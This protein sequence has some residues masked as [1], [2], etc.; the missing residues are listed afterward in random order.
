[1][2][3]AYDHPL[4]QLIESYLRNGVYHNLGGYER[5]LEQL[6]N[7][8]WA[9]GECA[10][11]SWQFVAFASSHRMRLKVRDTDPDAL[12]YHDRT[13]RG[14]NRHTVA[15]WAEQLSKNGN[16]MPGSTLYAVDWTCA[17]YGYD[18]FPMVL[19]YTGSGWERVTT[20]ALAAAA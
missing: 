13:I 2:E 17:Q 18:A 8:Q 19:L 11:L 5:S 15:V 12:G 7:P 14:V 6:R 10:N 9:G 16:A 20:P 1:M 4:S 3:L